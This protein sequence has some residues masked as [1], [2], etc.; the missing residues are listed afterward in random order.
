MTDT[1]DS[2]KIKLQICF[3]IFGIVSTV[4][5]LASLHYRDSL[6]CILF[7]RSQRPSENER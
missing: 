7:N 1:N 4:I 6:G 3:G 5:A 2:L